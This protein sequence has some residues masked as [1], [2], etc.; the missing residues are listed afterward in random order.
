MSV[1]AYELRAFRLWLCLLVLS[2]TLMNYSSS[3]GF[4]FQEYCRSSSQDQFGFYEITLNSLGFFVRSGS[5][6]HEQAAAR[7]VDMN[8]TLFNNGTLQ[9]RTDCAACKMKLALHSKLVRTTSNCP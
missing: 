6:H 5:H 7:A 1:A 9:T 3:T 4:V 8:E 2:W